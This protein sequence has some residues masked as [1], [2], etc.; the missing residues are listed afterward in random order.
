ML[1][2]VFEG[3]NPAV[4]AHGEDQPIPGWKYTDG[5]ERD[6][7]LVK[8][9]SQISHSRQSYRI[10]ETEVIFLPVH[11]GCR[12]RAAELR[13]PPAHGDVQLRLARERDVIE[14]TQTD[15]VGNVDTLGGRCDREFDRFVHEW[16]YPCEFCGIAVSR[17]RSL[18]LPSAVARA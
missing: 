4:L 3:L 2:D 9:D 8:S 7:F 15:N 5:A 14:E 16:S 12:A 1:F 13:I 6:F 10:A 17:R 11:Q 18:N